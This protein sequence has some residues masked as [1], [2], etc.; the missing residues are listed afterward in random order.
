VT[1]SSAKKEPADQA[2]LSPEEK[3]AATSAKRAATRAA[4]KA[5]ASDAGG[6]APGKPEPKKRGPK[7]GAK[8]AAEAAGK[9]G[10]SPIRRLR[11]SRM[12]TKIST[13]SK[14]PDPSELS[15]EEGWYSEDRRGRNRLRLRLLRRR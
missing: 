5:C 1:P 2:E 6:D 8:A 11:T 15:E 14:A 12:W 3:K 13:S 10:F 4:N 7:P 9:S